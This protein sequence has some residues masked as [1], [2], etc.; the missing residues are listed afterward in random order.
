MANLANEAIG[1][2]AIE[3]FNSD[4]MSVIAEITAD[5]SVA[6]D[7]ANPEDTV[8]PEAQEALVRMYRAGFSDLRL[9]VEH[10]ISDGD[11]V[12]TR[13]TSTGTHDGSLAGV[14]ATGKSITGSGITMDKIVDGKIV[15]AWTQW[16]NLGLMQQLGVGAPAGASAN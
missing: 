9:K 11:F 1:R 5:G 13:W 7:P 8:G 6:H 15:E 14:P 2:K 4:D 12:V 10:Q 16:D 3:V